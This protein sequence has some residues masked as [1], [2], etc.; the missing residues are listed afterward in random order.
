M[1][2]WYA[3]VFALILGVVFALVMPLWY[4]IPAASGLGIV[5]GHWLPL[6]G[7]HRRHIR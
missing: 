3:V 4:A 6:P 7:R 2:N 5:L 1:I